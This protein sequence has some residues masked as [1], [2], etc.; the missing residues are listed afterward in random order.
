MP[1]K[2]R[3]VI[4]KKYLVRWVIVNPSLKRYNKRFLKNKHFNVLTYYDNF[5][6]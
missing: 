3:Y 6:Y 4:E 2:R 5:E 1:S